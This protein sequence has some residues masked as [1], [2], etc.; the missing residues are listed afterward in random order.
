MYMQGAK[1]LTI[2][3]ELYLLYI[4]GVVA[5]IDK[6][7]LLGSHLGGKSIAH[8]RAENYKNLRNMKKT[9]II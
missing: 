9:S 1:L 3:L 4:V 2:L 5:G 8:G 7:F 6:C